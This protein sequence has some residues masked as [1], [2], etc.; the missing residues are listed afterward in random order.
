[1]Q[2]ASRDGDLV[3]R[4]R[5]RD[6]AAIRA[7]IQRH[8][9]RIYRLARTILR[10]D[11]EAEDVLQETY[12]KAFT[13]LQDFRGEA[14]LGTW[15]CRIAMNEALGRLRR[16][17]PT[18][19]LTGMEHQEDGAEIIR[20]PAAELDPERLTAQR[21]IRGLLEDAIDGLPEEFRV[22]LIARAV[23]EMSIEDTAA[24]LGLNPETVKTRLH[25]ARQRLR[26]TLES[27]L[28][29]VLRDVFPF[30]DPRCARIADNVIKR[31]GL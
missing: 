14:S 31:L 21:E 23:E 26:E 28:G 13:R 8:N 30:D 11:H 18:V 5:A 16:R 9:R 15:L 27:R 22:V 24:L 6:E 29:P 10:D 3:E 7:I 2:L 4:A 12:L 17:R 1:M 25:R 19:E 20:F